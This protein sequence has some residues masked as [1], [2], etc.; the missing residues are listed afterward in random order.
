MKSITIADSLL[1]NSR[2]TMYGHYARIGWL[3]ILPILMVLLTGG[4]QVATAQ[5]VH[6]VTGRHIAPVMGVNGAD[7]LEREERQREE[8]PEKA[9]LAFNL[10]PGMMVAD[11]GAGTGFYSLRLARAIG[12]SGVVYAEDI[13]PGMLEKLNANASAQHVGNVVTVLGTEADPRLPAGKLDL[14]LLVDVYHEFSRPQRM[15][16]RIRDSL[17]P[18]GRLVLLEFRKEDASVPIRPEHKMSVDEV[19][20]EVTPEGYRFEK[21]VDTLPWQHIIFF[22][23]TESIQ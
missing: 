2:K 1:R 10:K 4:Q 23:K 18:D 14:V 13:Q 8:Q 11:V 22:E 15:L 6:P 17:K 20:A 19:R 3:P 9:I 16:D 12:A 5:A 7:W 21:V